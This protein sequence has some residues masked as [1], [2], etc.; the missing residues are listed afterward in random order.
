MH[1]VELISDGAFPISIAS[2]L[3]PYQVVVGW[4][5]E[6]FNSAC[7]LFGGDSAI[8]FIEQPE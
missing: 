2:K 3:L 8:R 5:G 7:V 6:L 1:R 4:V